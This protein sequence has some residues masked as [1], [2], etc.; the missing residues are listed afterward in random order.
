MSSAKTKGKLTIFM[1]I[2]RVKKR[3]YGT[4]TTPPPATS[5]F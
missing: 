5:E 4:G 3:A 1:G 2:P